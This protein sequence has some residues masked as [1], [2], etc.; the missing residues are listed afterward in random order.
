M[1]ETE[2]YDK[3]STPKAHKTTHQNGGIDEIDVTDLSGV[4]SVQQ[5]SEFSIV[6]GLLAKFQGLIAGNWTLRTSAADIAWYSVCWSPELLLF[7][8]VSHSGH[9]NR[10]MTRP[11][12]FTWTIRTSAA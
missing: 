9:T 3:S 4:L 8:A 7:C 12:V 5:P 2:D 1:T 11:Y 10:V 6:S